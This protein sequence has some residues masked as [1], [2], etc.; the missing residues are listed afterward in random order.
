MG[1]SNGV[2]YGD[3]QHVL[4]CMEIL[5]KIWEGNGGNMS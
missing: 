1:C 2:H 5:A 3:K 4:D